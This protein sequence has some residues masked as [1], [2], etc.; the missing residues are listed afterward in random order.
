MVSG[1][2]RSPSG[3]LSAQGRGITSQATSKCYVKARV[4]KNPI[5]P[6]ISEFCPLEKAPVNDENC[7]GRCEEWWFVYGLVGR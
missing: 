1:L 6:V 7:V 4:D 2:I 3:I 5:V